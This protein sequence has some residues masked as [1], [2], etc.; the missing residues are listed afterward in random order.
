ML[1][2]SLMK[3]FKRNER[4]WHRRFLVHFV[5]YYLSI[6]IAFQCNHLRPL[7]YSLPSNFWIDDSD[8]HDSSSSRRK[9]PFSADTCLATLCT[10]RTRSWASRIRCSECIYE[11]KS[12]IW[13]RRK[14]LIDPNI[15]VRK[16]WFC[17]VVCQKF[18]SHK[19]IFCCSSWNLHCCFL[20]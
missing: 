2:V 15:L 14:S 10:R 8:S 4:K 18:R 17:L 3:V 13:Y 16:E 5:M 11:S 9:C 1:R 12:F 7:R 6:F 19:E 20:W